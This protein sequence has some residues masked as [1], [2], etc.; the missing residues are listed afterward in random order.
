M[1][2]GTGDTHSLISKK[3]TPN[4]ISKKGFW[5][6]LTND[7]RIPPPTKIFSFYIFVNLVS[8]SYEYC[9]EEKNLQQT[10][11]RIKDACVRTGWQNKKIFQKRRKTANETEKT[12]SRKL[13]NTM[14]RFVFWLVHLEPHLGI[15]SALVN[16]FRLFPTC[17]RKKVFKLCPK[18]F[19]CNF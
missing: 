3:T 6:S 5:L 8:Y 19:L 9:F 4:D 12:L 1:M 10:V 14:L 15:N 17:R 11:L 13:I 2:I 18:M 16:C 7:I